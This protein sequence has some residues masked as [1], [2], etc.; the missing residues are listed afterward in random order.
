[1]FI[2]SKL[3]IIKTGRDNPA[4]EWEITQIIPFQAGRNGGKVSRLL[5]AP[6]RT[7]S[8]PESRNTVDAPGFDP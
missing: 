6:S 5:W 3:D 1:M 8:F 7:N 4:G 2:L